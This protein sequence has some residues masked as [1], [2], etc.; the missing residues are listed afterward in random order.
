MSAARTLCFWAVALVASLLAV[1]GCG[2]GGSGPAPVAISSPPLPTPTPAPGKL[3]VDHNGILFE[4]ALPLKANA[5]PVRRL[6]EAPGSGIAPQLAVAPYGSVAIVTA[7]TLRV[8][9]PPVVSFEPAR[10]QV[11]IP[12]TPAITQVGPAGAELTDAEYDPNGNLWLVNV[13]GEISELAAPTSR[14][15][16]TASL[17]IQFGAPGTKTSGFSPVHASFDVNATL[18]VF[19]ATSNGIQT[20]RLFKVG[21]PYAKPPSGTGLNLDFADFVDSTQYLPTNP[22]PRPVILGQ[23]NGSLQSPPPGQ[24]PPPPVN[25]LAQFA[26]PLDPVQ[27][28]FPDATVNTLV[29]AVAADAPRTVFYALDQIT[30]RL[31]VYPLPMAPNAK[32]VLTLACLGGANYCSDKPEHLFL[33]P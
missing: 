32:P 27:G 9:K 26:Q 10:A 21:F 15:T 5:K 23:Y 7:T 17:T 31:D 30:G 16:Q 11:S 22:N 8:F 20:A 19:A 33:A 12:L 6:V 29:G 14:S 24:P 2:G 3:Y 13:L 18:Y 4:Y 1:A 28:L 25:R